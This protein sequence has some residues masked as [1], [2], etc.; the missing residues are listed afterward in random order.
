[1]AIALYEDRVSGPQPS[2]AAAPDPAVIGLKKLAVW[3]IA[4]ALPWVVIIG[5]VRLAIAALS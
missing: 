3:L 1:M 5:A 2:P 4:A